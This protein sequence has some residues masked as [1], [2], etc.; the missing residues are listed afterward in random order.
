[1]RPIFYSSVQSVQ[2]VQPK[3]RV[4]T[5]NLHTKKLIKT[6]R[7][8]LVCRCAGYTGARVR[9]HIFFL[10]FVFNISRVN[11]NNVSRARDLYPAHP[12]QSSIYNIYHIVKSVQG[13]NSNP[14]QTAQ[15]LI[16]SQSML[17]LQGTQS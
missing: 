9:V 11:K 15:T 3:C 7:N 1:M 10:Y 12:A 4:K 13:T 6:T 8:T 16:F 17:C 2:S 14:A 5:C